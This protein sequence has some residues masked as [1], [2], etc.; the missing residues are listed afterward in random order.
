MLELLFAPDWVGG[1][2]CIRLAT[3]GTHW[4]YKQFGFTACAHPERIMEL[5]RKDV[6]KPV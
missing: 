4:L 5:M 2:R 1:L 6:Y 3:E